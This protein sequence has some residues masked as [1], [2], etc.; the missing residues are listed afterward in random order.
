[1]KTWYLILYLWNVAG[2]GN[3]SRGGPA[4]TI[5]EAYNQQLCENLGA[6]AKKFFDSKLKDDMYKSEPT[7]FRCIELPKAPQMGIDITERLKV[8]K[9]N[10]QYLES[11]K[12][13]LEIK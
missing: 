1:M 7:D 2:Y 4:L 6:Q 8:I 12:K 9:E 5:V 11:V 3:A 10:Q 13:Q